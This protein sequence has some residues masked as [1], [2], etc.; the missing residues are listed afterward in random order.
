MVILYIFGINSDM[1]MRSGILTILVFLIFQTAGSAQVAESSDTTD[2]ETPAATP[3]TLADTLK[4]EKA[5]TVDALPADQPLRPIEG[6]G[7]YK[8]TLQPD[9]AGSLEGDREFNLIRAADNGQLEIVKF[10]VERG[11]NVDAT[12]V[13]EVTPLMYASQNGYTEI[14]EFLISKGA[15]VNATPYNDVT[16]LIGAVRTGHYESVKMLLEAGAKVD[17]KD[18]LA[19]TSLMHASAYDYPE[20]ADLLIEKGADVEAGDWFGTRPLMMAVYYD[21]YETTQ[22]LIRRGADVNARDTFGFTALM[23]AAQHGD[24]DMAWLLLDKGA[25]PRLQNKGGLHA[26]AMAVMSGDED[27]IELLLESGASINQHINYSTNA[28]S[29]AKEEKSEAMVTFLLENKAHHNRV[30]EIS[31][32]RFEVGLDFSADDLMVGGEIGLSENKYDMFAT[33]GFFTRTS[34]IRV[35][36][37]ENDTLSYQFWERRYFLPLTLGKKFTFYRKQNISA[38]FKAQL[39][40]GITWG[41][42]RGSDLHPG[43]RFIVVPSAGLYWRDRYWGLSFDYEYVNYKVHD[44]SKH[45]FRLS[46]LFFI[47]M[48]KRM[49]YTRK[50]ISWF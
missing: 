44:L 5:D 37:P 43:T 7:D 16:P 6:I 26:I 14:I 32:I 4:E 28:L 20:I 19:L 8:V 25:D 15:D 41:G 22:V 30:P 46:L 42:Y 50:D 11:V 47:N 18:E 40:G 13:D 33:T 21:C 48:Q 38:G 12:T 35:I 9:T 23:I 10:L 17:A 2:I 1:I 36:R 3:V 31:G 49:K 29:L 39:R 27:I 34:A 24:Y 45:R